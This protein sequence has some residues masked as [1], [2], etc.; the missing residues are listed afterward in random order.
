MDNEVVIKVRADN[1]TES[2]YNAVR[3]STKKM[4]DD[5]KKELD[6][7]GKDGGKRFGS[8]LSGGMLEAVPE[9]VGTLG[10]GLAGAGSAISSLASSPIGAKIGLGIAAAAATTLA[11][12]LGAA[13]SAGAGA[14]VIGAGV[15]VA[16]K[17]SPELQTA[18]KE[19]GTRFMD[20]LGRQAAVYNKPIMEALGVLS[21]SGDRIAG[22]LGKAFSATAGSIVPLVTS[23]TNGVENLVDSIS[24]IASN[25]GGALEGLGESFE[26]IL[27]SLGKGLEYMTGTGEGLGDALV[28]VAG[29]IGK[30]FEAV[31]AL[32]GSFVTLGEQTGILSLLSGLFETTEK[33]SE[34]AAKSTDTL[35]GSMTAAG[36][37]ATYERDALAKL[38][39]ELRAQ[40]D[41][42]FGL[43]EAQEDLKEAQDAATKAADKYGR[44]SPEYRQALRDQARAAFDLEQNAGKLG[45]TFN[46]KMSPAMRA[47]LKAAGLT[48]DAIRDLEKEFKRAQRAGDNFA[49]TYTANVVVRYSTVGKK[50]GDF[51]RG[52]NY[53]GVGGLASGG[54]KGAANGA[55]SSGLTWVGERGAELL[56]LPPGTQVH[57]SGDSDRIMRQGGAGIGGGSSVGSGSG[58]S[59]PLEIV[60]KFDPSYAPAAI[61]GMMEGIRAEVRDGG[62]SVQT[63]LGV[64]GVAA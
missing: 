50:N 8:G 62:G 40:A 46:G 5:V 54:I 26:I 44:N 33:S 17:K 55:M 13:V 15:L 34:G 42:V 16:V 25:S 10:K 48:E 51:G 57:S 43:M 49:G 3:Q 41:P 58:G 27:T 19:A 31:G 39:D 4:A 28:V 36:E 37:A 45:D 1:M 47:S 61:A 9:I 2:D 56:D 30:V 60:L 59:G 63:V 11:P 12:A 20:A 7:S 32:I 29:V 23:I 35:A 21:A 53:T 14:A 22:S 18:G 24:G 52:G 38:S 6:L 64:A